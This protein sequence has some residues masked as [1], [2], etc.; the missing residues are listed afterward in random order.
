MEEINEQYQQE[1]MQTGYLWYSYTYHKIYGYF[2]VYKN[3]KGDIVKG[4]YITYNNKI[5]NSDYNDFVCVDKINLGQFIRIEQ[6]E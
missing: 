6:N 5:N 4:N 3:I 2:M 1:S